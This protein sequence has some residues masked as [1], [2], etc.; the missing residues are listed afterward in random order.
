VSSVAGQVKYRLTAKV[1]YTMKEYQ[2]GFE[3]NLAL[4]LP[5]R[6]IA[7][8]T[9]G[10]SISMAFTPTH[11]D[12]AGRPTG[13][14]QLVAYHQLPYTAIVRDPWAKTLNQKYEEFT[15]I[16]TSRQA[17]RESQTFESDN[18]GFSG[19]YEYESDK[20]SSATKNY[21]MFLYNTRKFTWNCAKSDTNTLV[22]VAG[23][24]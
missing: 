3:R 1:P 7:Q 14:I 8:K 23:S 17:Q 10:G 12:N 16:R 2:V 24:G 22:V 21:D 18:F 4:E 6:V 13:E 11:L 20:H 5:I 9:A 15:P 19:Q